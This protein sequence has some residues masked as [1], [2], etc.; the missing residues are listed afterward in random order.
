MVSLKYFFSIQYFV[1]QFN[2][3][4][5]QIDSPFSPFL[6]FFSLYIMTCFLIFLAL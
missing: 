4:Y 1:K 2:T 5:F 6:F 3:L